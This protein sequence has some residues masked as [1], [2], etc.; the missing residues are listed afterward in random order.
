MLECRRMTLRPPKEARYVV[1]LQH[2]QHYTPT[3][4]ASMLERIRA[5]L[6]PLQAKAINLRVSRTA[7]EFDLFCNPDQELHRFLNALEEIGAIASYKRLD[8]PVPTPAAPQ[9]IAEAR[10]LFNQ[11]RYWEAHEVLEGLWRTAQGDEK[12]LL[13]GWILTAAALVHAQKNEPAVAN[14]LYEDALLRLENQVDNYYGFD[15]QRFRREV[16]KLA[17]TKNT[18]FPT[19]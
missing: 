8:L 10:E 14:A 17:L 12:R 16:K 7:I 3:D 15:V 18:Y 9:V 13:Q 5:T 11:E 19:I 1:R 6:S 4:Q 2:A